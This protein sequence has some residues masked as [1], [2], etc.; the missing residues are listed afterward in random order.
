VAGQ[1]LGGLSAHEGAVV[2]RRV[3]LLGE[4]IYPRLGIGVSGRSG[5]GVPRQVHRDHPV[6]VLLLLAGVGLKAGGGGWDLGGFPLD[7]V[8]GAAGT[9]GGRHASHGPRGPRGHGN[10]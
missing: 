3:H 9:R 6:E 1:A 8:R 2:A 4:A 10:C 5:R 7:G